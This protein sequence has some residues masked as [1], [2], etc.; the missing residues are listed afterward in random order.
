MN[1]VNRSRNMDR[2]P[3]LLLVAVVVA[4]QFGGACSPG[5]ENDSLD[6]NSSATTTIGLLADSHVRSG[7][8]AN[9]NYGSAGKVKSDANDSGSVIEAYVRFRIGDVGSIS[10]AR[11]RLYVKN[12]SSGPLRVNRVS[13]TSWSET[14]ITWNN[15]PVVDGPLVATIGA[16][17]AETWVNVDITS[18]ARPNTTISLAI[19]SRT[20]DGF[21]FSSRNATSNRPQVVIDTADAGTG[22]D[23]LVTTADGG[24]VDS[25]TSDS[26]V[27]TDLGTRVVYVNLAGSNTTGDGSF[28][29]PYRT[30]AFAATRVPSNQGYTI[31]LGSGT[32]VE[33]SASQIPTG[34]NVV[35]EGESSTVITSNIAT[36]LIQLDSPSHTGGNQLVSGIRINGMNRQLDRGLTIFNRNN[37]RINRVTFESIEQMGML[38]AT[39][40]TATQYTPPAFYLT[41]IEISNSTFRNSGV[42][43]GQNILGSLNIGH[44]DGAVIHDNVFDEDQGDGIKFAKWGYLKRTKIY[45]NRFTVPTYHSFWKS[46]IGI[47]LWNFFEDNEIYNNVSN[48]W[49]SFAYGNRGSGARSLRVYG[50]RIVLP[51]DNGGN[52]RGIEI[53]YQLSDVEISNN[54]IDNL[55]PGIRIGAHAGGNQSNI[56][57]RHNVFRNVSGSRNGTGVG[58]AVPAGATFSGVRIY[59][60]VFDNFNSA[61]TLSNDGVTSGVS[62]R[63]NI[64]LNTRY[65]LVTMGDGPNI[66]NTDI[67]FNDFY[68]VSAVL[69]EW[70]GTSSG[71]SVSNNLQVNPSVRLSG[72]RPFPYYG[73]A[74]SSPMIN[75]GYN[76]GLPYLGSAPD[77]GA[78]ELQ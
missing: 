57:V 67:S 27:S 26:S 8:T 78:F 72:D 44:L 55:T 12:G 50:N 34:V 47:E 33:T 18:V 3:L 1:T 7:T 49:F 35:G 40:N 38:V 42:D 45:N 24:T 19:L 4:G 65:G 51:V 74:S 5:L 29:R 15:K 20:S 10:N 63:N 68:L 76:V 77:I 23:T 31:H 73:L 37:V 58:F 32:F 46:C 62:M 71:T 2:A 9:T 61:A 21:D 13:S 16:T 17:T 75:A 6:L 48:T 64:V 70:G 66:R 56:L 59:N 30:L 52:N 41:G 39:T 28:N 11:L 36:A 60:N 54:F 69:L 14:S 22:A 53:S 25:S 43:Y